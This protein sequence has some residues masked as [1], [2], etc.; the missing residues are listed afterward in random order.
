MSEKGSV[1]FVCLQNLFFNERVTIWKQRRRRNGKAEVMLFGVYS[2]GCVEEGGV[3]GP[4]HLDRGAF[5][6]QCNQ[7]D[8]VLNE[9]SGDMT[10][11]ERG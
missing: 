9:L 11:K 1:L 6:S 8:E 5:E 10:S 7:A 3:K 4:C 2:G